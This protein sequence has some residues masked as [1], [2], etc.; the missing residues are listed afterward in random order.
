MRI[1][2]LYYYNIQS[3]CA[4]CTHISSKRR[5]E[6]INVKSTPGTGNVQGR[7][8][9]YRGGKERTEGIGKD[10]G[11]RKG[12]RIKDDGK[13]INT[14]ARACVFLCVCQ[15][16]EVSPPCKSNNTYSQTSLRKEPTRRPSNVPPYPFIFT[17][18]SPPLTKHHRRVN[19]IML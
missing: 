17:H 12:P 14:N 11:N 3:C 19:N 2:L 4:V 10:R 13:D 5:R 8:E 1:I 15:Q 16:L 18:P 7:N 9:K 6:E